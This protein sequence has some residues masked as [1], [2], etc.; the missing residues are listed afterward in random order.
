MLS[1]SPRNEKQ[2]TTSDA[3]RTNQ[4]D[5]S[6]WVTLARLV[7]PQ[8]RKGELLAEILT[9]FPERFSERRRLFLLAAAIAGKASTPPREVTL[10][11]HWL[12]KDRLVLKFAGI[13]SINDAEP[14]RGSEVVI[15]YAER[16]PLDEDAVYIADLV[17]CV[18]YDRASGTTVGEIL[19]VDRESSNMELLVVQP[20]GSERRGAEILVPFAKAYLPAIDLTARRMEMTLPDGLLT[21]DKPLTDEERVALA[22]ETAQDAPRSASAELPPEGSIPPAAGTPGGSSRR[23]GARKQRS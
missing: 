21:L 5:D 19:D 15:P 12:H 10:E 6:K 1:Q 4:A 20:A 18:L 22:V 9:D 3:P 23:H 16:A 13:D 14:L 7:K 17:G 2:T 8:G 11:E